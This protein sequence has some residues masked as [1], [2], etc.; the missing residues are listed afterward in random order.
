[1][2]LEVTDC[3]ELGDK[4]ALPLDMYDFVQ[5]NLE[6]LLRESKFKIKGVSCSVIGKEFSCQD[7][8]KMI[9]YGEKLFI[10]RIHKIIKGK[11]PGAEALYRV[12]LYKCMKLGGHT[13]DDMKSL[14]VRSFCNKFQISRTTFYNH[15]GYM[16]S[17]LKQYPE[18]NKVY[19]EINTLF[20]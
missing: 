14:N 18:L 1:M 16:E 9:S 5:Q 3:K 6:N 13:F 2:E 8:S 19:N 11:K 12:F 10:G 20:F 4:G 17:R 7:I 15:L